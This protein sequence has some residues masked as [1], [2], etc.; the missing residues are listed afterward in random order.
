LE[1]LKNPAEHLLDDSDDQTYFEIALINRNNSA[2]VTDCKVRMGEVMF[3]Q[4]FIIDKDADQFMR[5]GVWFHKTMKK[6]NNKFYGQTHGPSFNFLSENLQ[7]SLVE[8]LYSAGVRPE[9]GLCVEY[10]SWNKEQRMYMGWLRD[11]YSHLFFD[12]QSKKS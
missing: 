3:N 12:G 5:D 11:F 9:I 7:N 2:L 10:L 8:Y 4:F 6:E 1:S